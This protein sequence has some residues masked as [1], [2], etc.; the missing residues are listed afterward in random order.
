VN[1]VADAAVALKDAA[2]T[3]ETVRATN[4]IAA[5]LDPPAVVIGPPRLTWQTFCGDFTPT[6]AE[7]PVFLVVRADSRAMESLW[8]L[9]PQVTAALASLNNVAVESATPTTWQAGDEH[10]PAYQLD[11][12]VSLPL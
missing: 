11:V 3:V 9:V 6:E 12:R 1:A 2:D 4:D 7:F 10:F 8:E 5:P